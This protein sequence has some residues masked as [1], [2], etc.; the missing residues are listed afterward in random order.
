MN[1]VSAALGKKG[2][3]PSRAATA[4]RT[5]LSSGQ[6]SVPALRTYTS[7][8]EGLAA[9]L[10]ARL[11]TNVVAT[12]EPNHRRGAKHAMRRKL[13]EIRGRGKERARYDHMKDLFR[14]KN[15]SLRPNACMNRRS[16]YG[17]APTL[18][19]IGTF[20][21]LVGCS[22]Q[23]DVGDDAT[24][25][26]NPG[27]T[28]PR[29]LANAVG[30]GSEFGCA[31]LDDGTV[32]CWGANR[33]GQA[34]PTAIDAIIPT[35]R[36]VAGL[37]NVIQVTAGGETACAL[38]EGHEVLCWGDARALVG[39][40]ADTAVKPTPVTPIGGLPADIVEVRTGGP[41]A[42]A[43]SAS[44][45]VWCWGR[46]STPRPS[47]IPLSRDEATSL[48]VSF[49]EACA[50]LG[51]AKSVSC[52]NGSSGLD[53]PG[54]SASMPLVYGVNGVT[55]LGLAVTSVLGRMDDGTVKVWGTAG[56]LF[57]AISEPLA[58][59][60]LPAT[61][62]PGLTEIRAVA[63]SSLNMCVLRGD[64]AVL[65]WGNNSACQLGTGSPGDSVSTP[66]VVADVTNASDIAV[67]GVFSCALTGADELVCW[68]NALS[69][70]LGNGTPI[71]GGL[72]CAKAG[73]PVVLPRAL[74]LP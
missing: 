54:V 13:G 33:A 50:V 56:D 68:G 18:F 29:S 34:D 51:G 9:A 25:S 24:V 52:W 49:M 46:G 65:C 63:A 45:S 4:L 12:R 2:S 58:Y 27:P 15:L 7:R 71:E 40:L 74:R 6:D 36:R 38:T 30:L 66:A 26:G 28:G 42:C 20:S 69:G 47:K 53:S 39:D 48:A 73:K 41:N 11:S 72:P 3:Y 31:V 55:Q 59:G 5:A 10:L 37:S 21:I 61:T 23:L 57:A 70:A 17:V 22:G 1:I 44:G 16:H 64:G 62:F 14:D 32:A 19:A 43:R 60:D 8:A 67:G 35:P